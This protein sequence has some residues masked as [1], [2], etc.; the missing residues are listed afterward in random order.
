MNLYETVSIKTTAAP[1]KD[2]KKPG[3]WNW[4]DLIT[5]AEKALKQ[6]RNKRDKSKAPTMPWSPPITL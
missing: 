3:Y 4:P 1:K 5:L 6:A 2:R